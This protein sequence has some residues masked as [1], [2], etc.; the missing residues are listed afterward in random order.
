MTEK[1]ILK[2]IYSSGKTP[3]IFGNFEIP[4][5]V[6][7]D[8]QRV[9]SGRGIQKSL[10]YS[11]Q[12]YGRALQALI[13]KPNIKE[14][15]SEELAEKLT[16]GIIEFTHPR[17]KGAG[18]TAYGY[19]ATILI[20]LCSTILEAKNADVLNAE[21]L[22]IAKHAEIIIRAV[23]KIGIIA[24]IDE[25]TGYQEIRD[26]K[27]LQEILDKYISKELLAWTK[28]FPDEFYKEMFRLKNWQYT[29]LSVK[30]PA[31]VGRLTNDVI[32]SRLAPGV[33]AVLRK[34]TPRDDRGR[35]KH[36]YHQRLTLD[37][38]VPEL[39]EHLSN[40]IILMKAS[41]G[42]NNF[43]RLIQRALPKFNEN[44]PLPFDEEDEDI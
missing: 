23:A 21:E 18:R 43:Y 5:Y 13:K 19:E 25:A 4:C 20:D 29:Q 6:L 11:P 34:I 33:L 10:G 16:S 27:A 15:I 42:W 31:L 2:A 32:Y 37:L 8:G 3:L 38:G 28:R 12:S 41:A 26:K 14:Y 36:R 40:V 9:L 39:T 22:I 24:L 1:K 17:S 35:T 30:R 44:I 7:E